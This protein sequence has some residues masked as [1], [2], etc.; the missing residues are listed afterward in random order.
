MLTG[1]FAEIELGQFRSALVENVKEK[2]TAPAPL[3]QR[4]FTGIA[5]DCDKPSL[6]LGAATTETLVKAIYAATGIYSLLFT[7]VKRVAL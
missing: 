3:G 1:I 2:K 6:T 5:A 4:R 7:G